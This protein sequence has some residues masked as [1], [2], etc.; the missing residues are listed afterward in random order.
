MRS[1]SP[2]VVGCVLFII[3]PLRSTFLLI[4]Y[5]TS[6]ISICLVLGILILILIL[7]LSRG[8]MG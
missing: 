2:E 8:G 4:I 3:P 5:Y 1:S 6:G 7:I